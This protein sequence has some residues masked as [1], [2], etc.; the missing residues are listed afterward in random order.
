MK[1]AISVLGS[2]MKVLIVIMEEP[3][4]KAKSKKYIKK[5]TGL[6]GRT[7]DKWLGRLEKAGLICEAPK[8][9][10][11]LCSKFLSSEVVEAFMRVNARKKVIVALKELRAENYANI[12]LL[13]VSRKTHLPPRVIEEDTHLL[14]S[15]H[16]LA[17]AV[18][19]SWRL[20][21]SLDTTSLKRPRR[22]PSTE[23]V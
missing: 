15:D 23:D 18:E 3:L 8:G 12:T 9:W 2:D 14:A 22:T 6:D 11:V 5:K 20:D 17:V 4:E 16:G 21:M 13:D 1:D 19:S 7:I 10:L